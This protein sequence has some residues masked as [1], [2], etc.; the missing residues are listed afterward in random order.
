MK[1]GG[2]I[3]PKP[4]ILPIGNF[5]LEIRPMYKQTH[6]HGWYMT[7]NVLN[8]H[9]KIEN[10][11]RGLKDMGKTLYFK[12]DYTLPHSCHIMKKGGGKGIILCYVCEMWRKVAQVG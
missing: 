2:G 1:I 12:R 3:L 4:K 7:Q 5:F 11:S 6:E 8:W 9:K 10:W